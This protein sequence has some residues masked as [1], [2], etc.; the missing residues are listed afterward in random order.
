MLLVAVLYLDCFEIG[1]SLG[2]IYFQFQ[3]DFILQ[4]HYIWHTL[5]LG[6]SVVPA[7]QY[8]LHDCVSLFP[9]TC[10]PTTVVYFVGGRSGPKG[11]VLINRV[12]LGK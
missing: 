1:I 12:P 10:V 3:L 11:F 4:W 5:I 9:P 7:I 2:I 6:L 8:S